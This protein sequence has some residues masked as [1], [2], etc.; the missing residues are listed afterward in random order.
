MVL[1][2]GLGQWSSQSKPSGP[3]ITTYGPGNHAIQTATHRYIHYE[4]G[5]AELYDHRVDPNEWENIASAPSSD[6]MI[7]QLKALLPKTNVP[8]AKHSSYDF[9]DYFIEV[10]R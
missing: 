10:L 9:N 2:H 8:N 5:S 6:G 4:D 1:G 7:E 3:A